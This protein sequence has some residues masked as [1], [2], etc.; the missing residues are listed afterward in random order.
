MPS[1]KAA[2]TAPGPIARGRTDRSASAR[3]VRLSR[4]KGPPE[5]RD[6]GST[7][8]CARAASLRTIRAQLAAD[9]AALRALPSDPR[10]PRPSVEREAAGHLDSRRLRELRGEQRARLHHERAR[11]RYLYR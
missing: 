6:M 11:R 10:T 4:A 3:R 5:V 1:I 9:R 7:R 2:R 8:R